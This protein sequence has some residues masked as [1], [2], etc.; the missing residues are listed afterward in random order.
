[1]QVLFIWGEA[2]LCRTTIRIWCAQS[3]LYTQC[4]WYTIIHL[5]PS[6][7][8]FISWCTYRAKLFYFL[9]RRLIFAWVSTLYPPKG[10]Q[11]LGRLFIYAV[12]T[13]SLVCTIKNYEIISYYVYLCGMRSVKFWRENPANEH[14]FSSGKF[15]LQKIREIRSSQFIADCSRVEYSKKIVYAVETYCTVPVWDIAWLV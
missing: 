5:R 14:S 11:G 9:L 10:G 4:P 13:Y 6:F 3:K 2:V 8:A 12:E 15:R 1:M 7:P